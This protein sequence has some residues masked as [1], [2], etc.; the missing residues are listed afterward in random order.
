[1]SDL[2]TWDGGTAG[3]DETTIEFAAGSSWSM[4]VP[5][6]GQETHFLRGDGTWAEIPVQETRKQPEQQ[7]MNEPMSI[8][9]MIVMA[10]IAFTA[11]WWLAGAIKDKPRH[12]RDSCYIKL[13]RKRERRMTRK[14]LVEAG[15]AAWEVKTCPEKEIPVSELT[16]TEKGREAGLRMLVIHAGDNY[17]SE[18]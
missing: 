9:L 4:M 12:D 3:W 15:F 2:L 10:C 14:K 17:Y 16:L 11:G 5:G 18:H 13:G 6:E 8:L 7:P 1:M